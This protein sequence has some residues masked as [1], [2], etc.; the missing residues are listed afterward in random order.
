MHAFNWTESIEISIE[1]ILI[2]EKLKKMF[3]ESVQHK[4]LQLMELWHSRWVLII[5]YDNVY[6]DSRWTYN[7]ECKSKLANPELFRFVFK[8]ECR[9][10]CLLGSYIHHCVCEIKNSFQ[11]PCRSLHKKT[12]KFQT[13]QRSASCYRKW[14][15]FSRLE[16]FLLILPYICPSGAV[17]RS[18]LRCSL[19]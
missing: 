9:T 17:N 1:S 7:F 10:D 12:N 19:W 15:F 13:Q 4:S 14:N 8:L 18:A 16:R 11:T 2:N 5:L 3:T 6:V